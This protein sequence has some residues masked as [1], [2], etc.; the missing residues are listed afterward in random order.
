MEIERAPLE[1]VALVGVVQ[2]GGEHSVYTV[3]D[4][5]DE[6]ELL[7]QT[8]GGEVVCRYTQRMQAIDPRTYVGSGK[9][10]E[11]AEGVEEQSIDGVIFDDELTPTQQR[12]LERQLGIKVLDRTN[13]ILDIFAQRARTAYAKR[14]VELAQYEYLLPRLVGRWTH[15]ERQQG[16][17]GT[18]GPGERE[19]ETDRRVVRDK[20]ARLKRELQAVD[21]QMATQRRGRGAMPRVTLVGYTNVGKSTVL[22]LLANE[23]IYVE[24][25]LFATL[26]TT[27]RRVSYGATTYLLA[28]TVGF[29]RK[30]PTQLVEAFKSTLDEVREADVLVHVVDISHPSFEA[31]IAT[32][33]ETLR[34][35]G[36]ANKPTLLAFNK[37]DKYKPEPRDEY[38]LTPMLPSQATLEELKE[39]WMARDGAH[40][41]FFSALTGENVEELRARIAEL[42]EK[43]G[44]H[45]STR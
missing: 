44:P 12:N 27:V 21:K 42:A 37:I 7:V 29:I 31:Q 15:L 18:R 39:S 45:P 5:L 35:L 43:Y 14:Q 25:Q 10:K 38:D 17:I 16:G 6:L 33:N 20:N 41:V 4:Y 9:V 19:I 13:L 3:T 23:D 36:A 32:V 24:A 26:D 11:I 2:W 28:D 22:N 8:A 30:L 1:R 40:T 34:D